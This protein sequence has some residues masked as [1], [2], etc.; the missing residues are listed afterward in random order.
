VQPETT[1][2]VGCQRRSFPR[3]RRTLLGWHL[4]AASILTV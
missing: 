2:I 1:L 4:R 3:S